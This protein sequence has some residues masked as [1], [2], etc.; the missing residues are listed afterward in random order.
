MKKVFIKHCACLA[1]LAALRISGAAL[2]Q[3]NVPVNQ[4]QKQRP[5]KGAQYPFVYKNLTNG[6]IFFEDAV[7][8][9]TVGKPTILS[10]SAAE[11]LGLGSDDG[12]T[13]SPKPMA[14]LTFAPQFLTIKTYFP[15]W[16][17]AGYPLVE[18]NAVD[19]GKDKIEFIAVTA[20]Q[21]FS[22]TGTDSDGQKATA[23]TKT[24]LIERLR[25]VGSQYTMIGGEWIDRIGVAWLAADY[26][27]HYGV[28]KDWLEAPKRKAR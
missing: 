5:L 24:V 4:T 17:M 23:K 27:I 10:W 2:A 20:K 9:N 21:G 11:A 15:L 18:N 13:F 6:K 19:S 22:L 3:N 12:V 7:V 25:G 16:F 14:G 28:R 1:G 8:R 26:S